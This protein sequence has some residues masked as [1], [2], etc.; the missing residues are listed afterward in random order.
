MTRAV[1][2]TEQGVAATDAIL[3]R[4]PDW[5]TAA[6]AQRARCSHVS[7]AGK[8]LLLRSWGALDRPPLLLVH[9]NG[10]HSHWWDHVAPLLADTWSVWAL[11]LSGFGGSER[12]ERYG[13]GIWADEVVAVSTLLESW[14]R[15]PVQVVAHSMGGRVA[16]L[17]AT[18]ATSWGRLVV[19]DSSLGLPELGY[20]PQVRNVVPGSLY[21]SRSEIISRFR[22]QPRQRAA[23]PYVCEHIAGHSVVET[24]GGWRWKT[25]PRTRV[26]LS[27]TFDAAILRRLRCEISLL[28]AELGGLPADAAERLTRLSGV[29]VNER[30]LAMSHHHVMID[31]PLELVAALRDVLAHG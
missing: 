28:R 15:R 12:A 5:F 1:P 24:D 9:G 29:S 26:A 11:D 14:S 31:Q 10:A 4:A 23:L 7:V 16:A 8:G 2:G 13:M 21:R 22:L 3:N 6:L 25:D 18:N 20:V 19:V 17:A 27:E 30:L